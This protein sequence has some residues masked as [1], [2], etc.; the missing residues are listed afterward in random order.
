VEG[1]EG[2]VTADDGRSRWLDSAAER[3]AEFS[4]SRLAGR[5][6]DYYRSAMV[7]SPG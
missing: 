6:E 2:S 5:Y 7:R 4:M 1:S 3:A